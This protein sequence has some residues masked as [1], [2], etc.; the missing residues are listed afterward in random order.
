MFSVL[1]YT[2]WNDRTRDEFQR[3]SKGTE[4]ASSRYNPRIC[5]EKLRKMTK[6]L[7]QSSFLA[8]I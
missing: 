5:L 7:S 8:G 3:I 2:T 4:V 1:D 6:I